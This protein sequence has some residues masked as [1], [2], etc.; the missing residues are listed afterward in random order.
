MVRWPKFN[1]IFQTK[2]SNIKITRKFKCNID[3]SDTV[4]MN[5]QFNKNYFFVT[6][7]LATI[8]IGEGSCICLWY[9]SL[10]TEK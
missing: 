10:M 6:Q 4:R 2:T 8:L 7:S 3:T 5:V 9:V 1:S